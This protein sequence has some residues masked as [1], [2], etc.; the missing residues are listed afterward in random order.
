MQHNKL[1]ADGGLVVRLHPWALGATER[2]KD[3]RQTSSEIG[4]KLVVQVRK[5][6][7]R[8]KKCEKVHSRYKPFLTV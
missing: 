4:L 3:T 1:N 5:W 6:K 7:V 2:I 8:L